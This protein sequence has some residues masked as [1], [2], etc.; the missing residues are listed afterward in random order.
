M[1]HNVLWL[2]SVLRLI[3]SLSPFSYLIFFG[4]TFGELFSF[5][6]VFYAMHDSCSL[7][8]MA[9]LPMLVQALADDFMRAPIAS[10]PQ[11]QPHD[12]RSVIRFSDLSRNLRTLDLALKHREFGMRCAESKISAGFRHGVVM[13]I[14]A[15]AY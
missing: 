2:S 4:S 1:E 5:R 7:P 11:L 6:Q 8:D 9:P 3:L 13:L 15:M 14:V 12:A 10:S